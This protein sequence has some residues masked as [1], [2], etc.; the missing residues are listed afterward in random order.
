RLWR[1]E[2][3]DPLTPPFRH[4]DA[5]LSARFG[6]D[7]RNIVT[8]DITQHE[9]LWKLPQDGRPPMELTRLARLLSGGTIVPSGANSHRPADSL[10]SVWEQQRAGR[11]SD[12]ATSAEE[13]AAWHDFETEES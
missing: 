11:P 13:I 5:V 6:A 3:G 7:M 2:T 1:A 8:V 12:F 9:R 10:R 4:F